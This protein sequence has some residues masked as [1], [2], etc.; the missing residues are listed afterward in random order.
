[1]YFALLLVAALGVWLSVRAWP[2][3]V[4]SMLGLLGYMAIILP[5]LGHAPQGGTAD[6]VIG[7]ATLGGSGEAYA[8]AMAEADQ[9]GAVLMAL[10]DPPADLAPPA[11][12]AVVASAAPGDPT[13]I[14]MLSRGGW[15]AANVPGEPAMARSLDNT[16][17]VIAVNP[18]APEEGARS[19]P[20]RDAEI[21]RSGARAGVQVTPTLVL[22]DFEAVPW[23]RAMGQFSSYGNVERIRCGG[24][25][26]TTRGLL[27]VDHAFERG[28]RIADCRI[29]AVLESGHRPLFVSTAAAAAAEAR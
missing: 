2:P 21:N 25:F 20:E 26:A 9:A 28:V 8:R 3:V 1:M 11:G 29:G 24:P 13:A 6:R 23:N 27:A 12:W 22:G 17:T 5:T 18:P 19:S 15:R 16:L 4:V 10:G 7:W 14:T